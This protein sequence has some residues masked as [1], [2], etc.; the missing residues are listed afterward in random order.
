MYPTPR[1]SFAEDYSSRTAA[2]RASSCACA[3]LHVLATLFPALCNRACFRLTSMPS[4]RRTW[5]GEVKTS[6]RAGMHTLTWSS[7]E[8]QRGL[9][10]RAP[11][12]TSAVRRMSQ[13]ASR[14]LRPVHGRTLPSVRIQHDTSPALFCPQSLACRLR[15]RSSSRNFSESVY[16]K[17]AHATGGVACHSTT[18]QILQSSVRWSLEVPQSLKTGRHGR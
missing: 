18:L 5:R 9:P 6:K 2:Q 17:A 10:P 14:S 12:R 15:G 8:V 4:L 13:Y 11:E 7:K 1:L 3:V 16:L